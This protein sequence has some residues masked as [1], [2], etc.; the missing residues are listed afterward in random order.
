MYLFISLSVAPASPPENISIT[1]LS[2]MSASVSWIPPDYIDRNG[3][4][5]RY[6]V[7]VEN[8]TRNFSQSYNV[9]D[10]LWVVVEG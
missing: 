3:E 9:M 7:K 6:M 2:Y 8:V 1:V 10:M 4:I 5:I